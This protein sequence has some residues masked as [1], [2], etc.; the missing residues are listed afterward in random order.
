MRLLSPDCTTLAWQ[1]YL[2]TLNYVHPACHATEVSHTQ[3]PPAALINGWVVGTAIHSTT[4][5][6][7]YAAR[8][9]VIRPDGGP[10]A[11]RSYNGVRRKGD[12]A[13]SPA[14]SHH[15][16]RQTVFVVQLAGRARGPEAQDAFNKRSVPAVLPLALG[17]G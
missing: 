11:T 15:E 10:A 6:V 17:V 13:K 14:T 3:C 12:E 7:I 9:P 2:G 4:S 1:H 8:F 5:S 16:L